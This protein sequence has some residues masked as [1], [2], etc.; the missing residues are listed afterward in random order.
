MNLVNDFLNFLVKGYLNI[1]YMI[2]NTF[3]YFKKQ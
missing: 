3:N 2:L 1:Q